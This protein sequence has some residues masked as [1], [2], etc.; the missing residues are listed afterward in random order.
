MD[1]FNLSEKREQI[2]KDIESM[3]GS[4]RRGVAKLV[5]NRV[6]A[7][8]NEFIKILRN[9]VC[10]LLSEQKEEIMNYWIDKHSGENY[11]HQTQ[12]VKNK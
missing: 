6:V 9:H 5:L 12:E 8:D 11:P 10:E 1:E 3:I 2:R 7:Q 4:E